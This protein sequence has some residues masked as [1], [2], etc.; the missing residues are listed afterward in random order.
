LDLAAGGGHQIEMA[1]IEVSTPCFSELSTPARMNTPGNRGGHDARSRLV[2]QR[3][4]IADEALLVVR[5]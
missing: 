1:L 2:A 4:G 5:W 3:P